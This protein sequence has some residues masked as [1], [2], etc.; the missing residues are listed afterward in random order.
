MGGMS[1]DFIDTARVTLEQRK[2]VASMSVSQQASLHVSP[3][4]IIGDLML[5]LESYVLAEKLVGDT[6]E[7]SGAIEFPSSP[8]QFFKQRHAGSWWLRWLVVRRPVRLTPHRWGTA[9]T[10]E[11]YAHYP[12]AT[13][14]TPELGRP[15][16]FETYSQPWRP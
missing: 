5:R 7:V 3:D 2:V 9:V 15:V 11:R 16:V 8:W 6:K 10:F 14:R 13:L 1:E 12:E 4:P